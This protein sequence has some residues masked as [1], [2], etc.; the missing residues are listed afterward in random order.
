MRA[1][2]LCGLALGALFGAVTW[3]CY[4]T[5]GPTPSC[6]SDPNQEGCLAPINDDR[7]LFAARKDGGR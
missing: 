5:S 4:A 1:F 2:L 7:T 6:A 3:G